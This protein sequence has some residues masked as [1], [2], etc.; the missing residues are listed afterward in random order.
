MSTLSVMHKMHK[1][2]LDDLV[3]NLKKLESEKNVTQNLLSQ[4]LTTIKL[5]IN[6]YEGTEYSNLLKSYLKLEENKIQKYENKIQELGSLIQ[7]LQEEIL[8]G[9]AEIKKLELLIKN[10]NLKVKQELDKLESD[11]VD[12]ISSQAISRSTI[13]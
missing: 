4:T 10:K 6:R 1:H 8:E 5:E 3:Y 12:E 9:F 7:N 13:N 2:K 11:E